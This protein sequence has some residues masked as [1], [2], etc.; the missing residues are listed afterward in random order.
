MVELGFRGHSTSSAIST[1]WLFDGG[2][3]GAEGA[4]FTMNERGVT[5]V[6]QAIE[7]PR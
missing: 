6:Y 1:A 4:L 5:A 3:F 7:V 2:M